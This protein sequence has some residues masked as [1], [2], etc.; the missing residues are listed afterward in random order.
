MK[1][2]YNQNIMPTMFGTL[3]VIR[4]ILLREKITVVHGHSVCCSSSFA[5]T[6][7]CCTEFYVDWPDW[8]GIK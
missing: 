6:H 7:F 3:P 2:I 8:P 5:F 1:P 4:Y